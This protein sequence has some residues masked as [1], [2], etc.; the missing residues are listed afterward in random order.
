MRLN[1]VERGVLKNWRFGLGIGR[2]GWFGICEFVGSFYIGVIVLR[3]CVKN[4][5]VWVSFWI[6]AWW[7]INLWWIGWRKSEK[8]DNGDLSLEV[9]WVGIWAMEGS[10][11]SA[12]RGLKKMIILRLK[13]GGGVGFFNNLFICIII[14]VVLC[15]YM[16]DG[17]LYCIWSKIWG[18]GNC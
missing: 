18:I 16:P 9:G 10:N 12:H 17:T 6:H 11:L 8:W 15:Y 3:Y 7:Y 2:R 13:S 1:W 14:L 4:W 5:D